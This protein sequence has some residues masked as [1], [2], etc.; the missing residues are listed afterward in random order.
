MSN[1]TAS[2]KTRFEAVL[3]R[4]AQ[5]GDDDDW[6]FLVLPQAVSDTLPRRGRTSIE[7]T[8]NDQP[9]QATLEPDGK[10]S[11]WLQVD[12][13]LCRAA[14]AGSGDTVA[15]EVAPVAQEL[16]P[17]LP[18]DF[19]AALAAVPHAR[20]TWDATTTIARIDWIHWI[21]TAKQQKTRENR[22]HNACDMLATGKKRVC[23]FDPSGVYSKALGAPQAADSP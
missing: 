1:T 17:A 11:H 10:R 9:F 14:Q 2:E 3:Q 22:I 19:H 23:C 7:G 20:A 8:L 21:E 12:D 5:P 13:V 6:C 18:A 15:V 4:P 16:E